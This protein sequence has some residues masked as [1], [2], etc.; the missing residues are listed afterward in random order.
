VKP[1]ALQSQS[2]AAPTSGYEST[3][4]TVHGGTDRF[5]SMT[6]P[7]VNSLNYRKVDIKS[8]AFYSPIS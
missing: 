2:A 7:E 8:V 3:G 1:N 5:E 6:T 4:M